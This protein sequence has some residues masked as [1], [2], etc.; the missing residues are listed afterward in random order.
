MLGFSSFRDNVIKV[1][2]VY[3]AVECAATD[4]PITRVQLTILEKYLSRVWS[5]LGLSIDLSGH[6]IDRVNDPRNG[7][8]ISVC[9]IQRLF[10]E[11]AA[12]YGHVFAKMGQTDRDIESV[13]TG[14]ISNINI[15]VALKWNS[16]TRNFFLRPITIMRKK[17][18]H[19]K[20]VGG[21][22]RFTVPA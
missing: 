4:E 8:Q 6:F 7:Q 10:N 16:R 20:D 21:V 14:A 12:K 2:E 17:V 18:F 3:E 9:E 22:K 19:V 1:E 13:L 5:S 11:V 15:P